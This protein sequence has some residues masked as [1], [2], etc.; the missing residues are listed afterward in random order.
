M[1]EAEQKGLKKAKIVM[2]AVSILLFSMSYLGLFNTYLY[3]WQERAGGAAHICGIILYAISVLVLAL[4][5]KIS[6]ALTNETIWYVF[7]I[8]G[9]IGGI[10][11]SSGFNFSL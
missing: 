3:M 7:W 8:I 5:A 9:I 4:E 10:A 11:V 6:T 1:G 2:A